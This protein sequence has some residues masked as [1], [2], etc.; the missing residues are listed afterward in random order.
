MLGSRH[1]P[2]IIRTFTARGWVLDALKGERLQR[3]HVGRVFSGSGQP[4][5][6]RIEARGHAFAIML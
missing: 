5:A 1:G 4:V 3:F 2:T 6:D